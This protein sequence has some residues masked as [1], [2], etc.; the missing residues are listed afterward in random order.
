VTEPGSQQGPGLTPVRRPL[1]LL[2]GVL[3][4]GAIAGIVAIGLHLNGSGDR[5][6]P[7]PGSLVTS[8]GGPSATGTPTT[9]DP[10]AAREAALSKLLD[11][12]QHAV[13]DH[14]PAGWLATVDASEPAF[15]AAQQAVFANLVKLPLSRWHY[16]Y[17]APGLALPADRQA[18]LG[19]D[20]WVAD[21]D[22]GYRL[23]AADRS[24]VHSGESLTLVDRSGTWLLAGD[25]DG[26]TD[27]EIWDLGPLTVLPG[28]HSVVIGIGSVSSLKSYVA[29][30]DSA[31]GRVSA[32]WGR[33]WPQRVVVLVPKTQAQM[34]EL[35]GRSS[36]SLAQIAAV[37]TG[38]LTAGAGRAAGGADQIIVNPA[39]F[40]ELDAL[41]KRVVITHETTHVAVRAS[42][43]R[44]VSI[45]LSEGFADYIGF[46][47]LGLPRTD[48]A[49]DV[50]GEVRRGTGPTHLPD[51]TDFDATRTTVG[52]S[53]SAS[54]LA[55]ELIADRYGPARLIE[56]YRAAAGAVAIRGVSAAQSPDAAT[57]AAFRS[58]LGV[59]EP[60]FT[61]SWLGYLTTLSRQ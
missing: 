35:L 15:R 29:Q 10:D 28:D 59:S 22:L 2:G 11:A 54:W 39:G 37:T 55:C 3:V 43:P 44:A 48:V 16:T 61:K 32:I 41:G 49:A 23:G 33:G 53:Y 56:L 34:G 13:L 24:D 17:S 6:G 12:R 46:S 51:E 42:T 14:D 19:A 26:P 31:V 45:W 38:E 47:G 60:A 20:A 25:S 21:V 7:P 40:A 18:A 27:S 58:V 30:A 52:P 9:Q 36:A 4:A 8:S 5:S 1:A 50:L 57:E